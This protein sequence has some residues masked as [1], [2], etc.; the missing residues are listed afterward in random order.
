MSHQISFKDNIASLETALATARAELAELEKR[1]QNYDLKTQETREALENLRCALRGE[2]PETKSRQASGSLTSLEVNP[3]SGRPA[4]GANKLR[5]FVLSWARAIKHF[6][7]STFS[8][9][10]ARSKMNY[11]KA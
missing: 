1:S 4:L 8:T 10:C 11:L 7:P 6:A 5:A 3:E 9:F 2:V